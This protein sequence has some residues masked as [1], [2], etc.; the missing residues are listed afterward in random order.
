MKLLKLFVLLSI[1]FFSCSKNN[2]STFSNSNDVDLINAIRK[3]S[4]QAIADH[5]TTVL[6]SS[7]TADYH[8]ITSRNS[9]VSGRKSATLRFADEFKMR[10]DVVYI[11]TSDKIEVFSQWNMASEQGHW[12]GSWKEGNDQINISGSY[13]AKWHKINGTWF[14]RAELFVPL[15]CAGGKFCEQSPL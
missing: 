1:A 15:K 9:E 14:I 10:P 7:W 2:E 4:N 12:T 11:R 3:T 5:D 8:M 13:F 6:A